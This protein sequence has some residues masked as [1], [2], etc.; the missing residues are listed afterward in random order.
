MNKK[1]FLILNTF[2]LVVIF[3][4]VVWFVSR[5][6]ATTIV[7]TLVG[8]LLYLMLSHTLVEEIFE[9]E[10]K[11]KQK[12][13]KT[14]HE[15]NTPVSTI[16]INSRLLKNKLFE[17]KDIKR[18]SKIDRACEVLLDL[19]DEMEYFI[20]KNI[21]LVEIK[22]YDLRDLIEMSVKRFDDIKKDTVI[23]LSIPKTLIKTDKRG[24]LKVIDN[25]IQ[26]AI[27]HNPNLTK[28][29]IFLKE[30]TLYIKDDGDGIESENICNVFNKYF[31][32]HKAKGFGLGLSMVKE[33]CDK[34]TIDIKIDSSESGTVFKLNLSKII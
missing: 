18:L 22:A 25:L 27:K 10:N 33:F 19:Y 14:M 1:Y 23:T 15:L 34:N 9:K 13:Q 12:M 7:S 11:L 24:F 16:E 17:E 3:S 31:K 26:N 20:Q 30:K 5:D 4:V 6:F 32:D 8:V 2:I 29:E 28:I 21:D